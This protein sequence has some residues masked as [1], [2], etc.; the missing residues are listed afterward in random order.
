[1]AKA[2]KQA[3]LNFARP[4]NVSF[5]EFGSVSLQDILGPTE[6]K[7][8]PLEIPLSE[9][10]EDIGQP[11]TIFAEATLRELADSIM[12]Y[13]V[14]SP[15][16]VRHNPDGGYII[17]YGARRF[18]ASKLAGKDTIPAFVQTTI[19]ESVKYVQMAENIH[20]DNLQHLEIASFVTEEVKIGK[21][22]G[23]IAKSLGKSAAWISQYI[24]L[25]GG[26]LW[27][28][29]LASTGKCTN[30]TILTELIKIAETGE[31]DD[32]EIQ[33]ESM[34]AISKADI[35]NLMK[36]ANGKKQSYNTCNENI[37]EIKN[38][39]S[40]T[41]ANI[42][43]VKSDNN[44]N[45]LSHNLNLYDNEIDIKSKNDSN[46]D[47]NKV[48]YVEG[49]KGYIQTKNVKIYWDDTGTYENIQLSNILESLSMIS[50]A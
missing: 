25:D 44:I 12:I 31:V 48:V 24:K 13:G 46:P 19:N 3:N 37:L 40:G 47:F 33:I 49:R 26:P 50:P 1:M 28:K 30:L 27:I 22:K 32:L 29:N 23:D 39:I 16:S 15:I 6:N 14:L 10:Q 38:N 35:K 18:R 11:R 21:K 9:I 2:A 43:D 5:D 4:M 34:D 36:L 20:R 42:S 45:N 41:Q 7:G 8:V 17:N